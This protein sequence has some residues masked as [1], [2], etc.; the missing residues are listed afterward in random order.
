[1]IGLRS[2]ACLR[3][4]SPLGNVSYRWGMSVSDETCRG[5]RRV[6]NQACWSQMYHVEVSDGSLIRHVGL[7]WSIS[8]SPIRHVG[9][10]WNMSRSP[11]G[12]Q[13]GM[14][15]SDL[16]C[17]GLR[18]VFDRECW[19][20]MGLQKVW[21]VPTVIIFSWTKNLYSIFLQKENRGF[22]NFIVPQNYAN[23]QQPPASS[24]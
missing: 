9:L 13:S 17:R 23:H 1:M 11:M 3:Y 15:V 4:Q 8:R 5:L 20:L 2:H 24:F 21:W 22:S 18:W 10:R 7:C 19:S 12:L 14:L 16:A 6:S